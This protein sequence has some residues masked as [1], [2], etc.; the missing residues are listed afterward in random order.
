MGKAWPRPRHDAPARAPGQPHDARVRRRDGRARRYVLRLRHG[1]RRAPSRGA[2]PPHGRAGRRPAGRQTAAGLAGRSTPGQARAG[3]VEHPPRPDGRD[4]PRRPR[5]G[6]GP[7]PGRRPP[8]P[9]GRALLRW[10]G[11]FPSRRGLWERAWRAAPGAADAARQHGPRLEPP[12]RRPVP[13]R[14]ALR[15]VRWALDRLWRPARRADAQP[16]QDGA[17]DAH[18]PRARACCA[19]PG[20]RQPTGL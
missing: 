11:P 5:A 6:L 20:A 17:H 13:R 16:R 9:A 1:L 7:W 10:P 4:A 3:R 18:G 14:W 2:R 8:G 15:S 19:P 12:A